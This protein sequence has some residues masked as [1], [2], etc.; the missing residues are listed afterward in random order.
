MDPLTTFINKVAYKFPKGYPD[1]N[2]PK[3]KE[4]LFEMITGIIGEGK[5]EDKA[6][7]IEI[8][9]NTFKL[10]D[11]A[12]KDKGLNF[13]VLVPRPERQKYVDDIEK[14][15]GFI[16]N[17]S[18]SSFSSLGYLTYGD[19]KIAIKP[20]G[21]QGKGSAGLGNEDIFVTNVNKY[22]EN[23]P[24]NI[25]ITDGERSIE[26]V[27]VDSAK[28][29]G[30]SVTSYSK[31]DVNF[32]NGDNDLGG[33]SLKKNNAIYW[34][35]A[36]VRFKDEVNNLL[37]AILTGKLGDKISYKPLI[38]K[39]GNE[40][41]III[42][43]W[44]KETDEKIPGIV[45]TDLPEID[46]YQAIFGNDKVPV[47]MGTWK[48][49]DFSLQG[50]DLVIEASKVYEDI[51]DVKEDG[52]MPVLNIRHDMTKRNT[53]GLRALLQTEK[54]LYRDGKLVGKNINLPYNAFN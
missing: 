31:S 8:I 32:Y 51:E 21:A 30:T 43:M 25:I 45:V 5:V 28:G 14:L 19:V 50:D 15:D 12:F 6:K 44:N 11:E 9:K 18:P 3:D 49:S 29:T 42:R 39:R 27:D 10:D 38:D 37:D 1:M 34:E 48:D 54:S 35:S 4:M 52:A 26:W 53:R 40:D 41:P 24:L 20:S 2:D 22:L 47:A 23:G 7:A 13:H 46:T 17:P 33:V 36:D 16:Y